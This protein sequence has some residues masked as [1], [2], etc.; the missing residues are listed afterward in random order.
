MGTKR[1]QKSYAPK[2]DKVMKEHTR[3]EDHRVSKAKEK[4][5]PGGM[6]SEEDEVWTRGPWKSLGNNPVSASLGEM[7]RVT[8]KARQA[9]TI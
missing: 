5:R 9:T 6:R 8:E 1:R 3:G 2:R 7:R 4:F